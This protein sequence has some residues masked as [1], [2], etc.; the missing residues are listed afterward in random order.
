MT[1]GIITSCDVEEEPKLVVAADRML[2]AQRR[3]PLEFENPDTKM[4]ELSPA[5]DHMQLMLVYSGAVSLARDYT[6][7][8]QGTISQIRQDTPD[9]SVRQVATVAE[10]QYNALVRQR[11]ESNAL[12][13]FDLEM[14]DLQKQHKFKDDFFNKL[15]QDA[16]NQRNEIYENL[17]VLLGGVDLTGSYV[18][19]INHEGLK[20]HNDTGYVATGSGYQPAQSEFIRNE[21]SK[22]SSLENALSTT[23]AA[24]MRSET[25][26]GVGEETDI[27]VV[28]SGGVRQLDDDEVQFLREREEDIQTRQEEAKNDILADR[29]FLT[30]ANDD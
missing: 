16:E 9:M 20:N 10:E 26:Q 11:I 1:V 2:T 13:P 25:A 19:S 14:E 23:V 21:Y 28:E 4:S 29:R 12:K 17:Q 3:S 22:N 27:A 30:E 6:Q 8:L 5:A 18:F 24:K 15:W 7:Q